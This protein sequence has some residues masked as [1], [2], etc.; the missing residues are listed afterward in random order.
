MLLNLKPFRADVTETFSSFFIL[1]LSAVI[2]ED[3][4]K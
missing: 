1:G 2:K 3:K 4:R